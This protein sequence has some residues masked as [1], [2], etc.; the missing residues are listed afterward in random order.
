MYLHG[1]A[2]V[3]PCGAERGLLRTGGEGGCGVTESEAMQKQCEL[4]LDSEKVHLCRGAKC[5][6]WKWRE[7]ELE[8]VGD[9][10]LRVKGREI[11]K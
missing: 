9:C 7:T 6:R 3:L 1:V 4:F 8:G 11:E 5:I 2:L 10:R